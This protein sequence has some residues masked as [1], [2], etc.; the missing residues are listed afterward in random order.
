MQE[1]TKCV[2]DK[3]AEEV[4]GGGSKCVAGEGRGGK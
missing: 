2:W 1:E 3:C 4:S